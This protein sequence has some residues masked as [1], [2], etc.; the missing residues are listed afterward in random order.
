MAGL[1]VLA[2]RIAA[3][4]SER[5]GGATTYPATGHFGKQREDILVLECFCGEEA[6]QASSAYLYSLVKALG[7]YCQQEAIACSL[8]GHMLL[9]APAGNE[10]GA[11]VADDSILANLM[12]HGREP[13]AWGCPPKSRLD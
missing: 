9:V 1:K 6:W 2:A 10:P 12:P 5:F 4:L 3:M 8:D 11:S 7:R 13:D